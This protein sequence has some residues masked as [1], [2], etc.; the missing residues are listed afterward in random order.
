M[1]NKRA[2]ITVVLL[3]AGLVLAGC[4]TG[5]VSEGYGDPELEDLWDEDAPTWEQ[6]FDRDDAPQR[7]PSDEISYSDTSDPKLEDLWD[8]DAPSWSQNGG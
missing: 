4:S 1:K 7:E 5:L 6:P 3:A 8:E 2:L